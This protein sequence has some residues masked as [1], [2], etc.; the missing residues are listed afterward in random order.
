MVGSAELGVLA[1]EAISQHLNARDHNNPRQKNCL[2]ITSTPQTKM[3]GGSLAPLKFA[4]DGGATA[5][6]APPTTVWQRA[7]TGTELHHAMRWAGTPL[8]RGVSKL[9]DRFHQTLPLDFTTPL[10]YH[11]KSDREVVKTRFYHVVKW[12]SVV[13]LKG[14]PILP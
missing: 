13:K 11:G 6:P 1:K 2:G 7:T 12:V 5:H 10:F 14:V 9:A 4:S 8:P 3:L